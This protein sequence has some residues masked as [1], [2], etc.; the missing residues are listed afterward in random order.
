MGEHLLH[1]IIVLFFI[2]SNV[3]CLQGEQDAPASKATQSV[4]A[5][6]TANLAKATQNPVANMISVPIQ[7]NSNFG[8]GPYNRI[9]NVLNIQPVVPVKLGSKLNLIVRPIIPIINQPA[10]GTADLE[11]LG[12]DAGTPAYF[13]AVDLRQHAGVYGFGDI[14]PQFFLTPSAAHRIIFGAGPMF[15]LPSASGF[16]L[17]QG[18]FSMGPTIVVLTQ[19]GPWTFGALLNNVWSVAGDS[20]RSAVNQMSLQYFVNY[21]LKKGWVISSSPVIL[22][23]WNASPGKIWTVPFGGGVGR[24]MKLGLQPVNLSAAMFGNAV[25]PTAGSSWSLR[26]QIAFLFPQLPPEMK[27]KMKAM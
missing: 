26:L 21:N 25:H 12:I 17:G 4:P 8:I 27:A 16:V 15:T 7:N 13:A 6:S 22:A 14:S 1:A 24:I 20:S 9:Q 10:P 5:D 3:A 2:T 19:P 11:S 18:K 23:N